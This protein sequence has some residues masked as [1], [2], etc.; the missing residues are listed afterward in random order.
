MSND[1]GLSLGKSYNLD[2]DKPCFTVYDDQCQPNY[3]R[4]IECICPS[5]VS[6]SVIECSARRFLHHYRRQPQRH[7]C[8]ESDAQRNGK[9]GR[10]SGN[11]ASLTRY[12]EYDGCFG[13][14]DL[15]LYAAARLPEFWPL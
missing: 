5:I 8:M 11:S 9:D 12:C 7:D 13:G 6:Q 2:G 14:D 3:A 15:L 1:I 4:Y 10:T